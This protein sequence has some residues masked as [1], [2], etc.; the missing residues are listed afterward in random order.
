MFDNPSKVRSTKNAKLSKAYPPK[1]HR[2]LRR[3]SRKPEKIRVFG[4]LLAQSKQRVR[5]A[6][7]GKL[8]AKWTIR[9]K[10]QMRP[11]TKTQTHTYTN[12]N[13]PTHTQP[14]PRPHPHRIT[15][16]HTHRHTKWTRTMCAEG[17]A[18]E[19]EKHSKRQVSQVYP[20]NVRRGLRKRSGKREKTTSF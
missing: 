8:A 2:G 10:R 5:A 15:R 18:S 16:T 20:S 6:R 13:T 9:T 7:R 19:V 4:C 1:V 12:T 11:K 14:H 3:R 17:N